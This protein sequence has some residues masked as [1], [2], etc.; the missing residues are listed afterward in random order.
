[1]INKI[2]MNDLSS[3]TN[4]VQS[5]KR[6]YK[7]DK[8]EHLNC[9]F[10]GYFGVPN[11]EPL[12][13]SFHQKEGDVDLINT[14]KKRCHCNKLAT[15]GIKG[16]QPVHCKDHKEENEININ[17]TRFCLTC[18]EEGR[19]KIKRASYG[20][21]GTKK[22]LRCAEHKLPTDVDIANKKCEICKKVKPTFAQEGEFAK[23][24]G[25]CK[26][27]NDV[28]V[29]NPRCEKCGKKQPNYGNSEENILRYCSKCRL[30]GDVLLG[31]ILCRG[32]NCS[33]QPS[34]G[35][36]GTKRP[37]HCL[38]HK[39]PHE[40]RVVSTCKQ[41]NITKVSNPVYEGLC[42]NCFIHLHPDRPNPRQHQTKEKAVRTYLQQ[43]LDYT[44]KFDQRVEGG[45]SFRRPDIFID[46]GT[47]VVIVEI[48][49]LQ[50]SATDVYTSE[51]EERRVNELFTDVNFRP[52]VFLRFNPDSYDDVVSPWCFHPTESIMYVPAK[53]LP[54]WNAR[55]DYLKERVVYHVNHIP[56][57]VIVN[58]FLFFDGF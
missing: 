37:I 24:C 35:Q 6:K 5:N 23:R 51:C 9:S 3:T 8:C 40:V 13:C 52:V 16:S 34:F 45:C 58:E 33:K 57:D 11:G 31:R 20:I 42:L 30:P 50:H 27:E 2:K 18:T 38:T 55:L 53:K 32:L 4:A 26:L 21:H 17:E 22:V 49:E 29:N 28:D 1:M 14:S 47:H 15:F 19:E 12:R 43:H 25:T 39:L 46:A 48:D 56:S 36:S 41:C 7:S 44:M 10:S 54:Q